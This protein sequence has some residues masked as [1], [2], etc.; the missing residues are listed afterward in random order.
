[1][2]RI[3]FFCF[4]F[5]FLGLSLGA[6][7]QAFGQTGCQFKIVGT[8]KVANTDAASS[9]HYRFAEDGSITKLSAS[10]AGT[11][12]NAAETAVAN[13]TLDDPKAPKVIKIQATH[14]SQEFAKGITP[15][16]I[17]AF[18]ESSFTLAKP[19][20]SQ[21]QWVKADDSRYFIILAGRKGLFYD[22]SGSTFPMLVKLDGE[23][24]QVD[25][26][27]IY[28]IRNT[29]TFG[30][31]PSE[32]YQEFMKDS[33][34]ASDVMFRM[35][36]SG[37][38]YERGLQILRTWERRVREGTLLY[39]DISMDNILLVKQITES[40]NQCAE[41]IKLYNLD[42]GVDDKISDNTKP[43]H[44]PFLYFQELRRLNQAL[45]VGDEKFQHTAHLLRKPS[46]K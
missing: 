10:A 46:G 34:K 19:D 8:W 15:M 31:I 11:S 17:K 32:I 14:E 5:L 36:I 40:L 6:P 22:R 37:G 44:I 21:I 3:S 25:A 39:P 41:K 43:T 38:Q 26:L 33:G 30:P 18:D 16:T 23:K 35:E 28:A 24:T 2:K 45:H 42:W 29:P 13:Y 1:M 9:S 7:P 20:N 12:T 27:G 4:S